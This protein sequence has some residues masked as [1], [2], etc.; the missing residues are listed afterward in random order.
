MYLIEDK[1]KELLQNSTQNINSK[2]NNVP[3][4]QSMV[5]DHL[6]YT[7]RQYQNKMNK[8]KK[9]IEYTT[10][11]NNEFNQFMEKSINESKF[12]NW[13]QIQISTKKQLIDEYITNDL[14]INNN[15][16]SRYLDLFKDHNLFQKKKL[17][18][19]NCKKGTISNIDYSQIC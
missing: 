10:F 12:S 16:K 1:L 19:Y 6:M 8:S 14:N 11:S 15:D 5:Y 7:N 3:V 17:I 18:K 9:E 2:N 13:K 4:L